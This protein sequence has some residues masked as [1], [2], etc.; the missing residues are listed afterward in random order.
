MEQQYRV[1]VKP[2]VVEITARSLV[3]AY[4][5]ARQVAFLQVETNPI[6]PRCEKPIENAQLPR[7]DGTAF[8]GL[9]YHYDCLTKLKKGRGDA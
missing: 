6:C 2:T 3:S 9:I 8:S 5:V 4:E 7:F 1:T